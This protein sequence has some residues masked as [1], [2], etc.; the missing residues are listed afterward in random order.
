MPLFLAAVLCGCAPVLGALPP[1]NSDTLIGQ[2]ER[3]NN[4]GANRTRDPADY[5]LDRIREAQDRRPPTA[6]TELDRI[7][8]DLEHERVLSEQARQEAARRQ[9]ARPD[10]APR[11]GPV[12]LHTYDAPSPLEVRHALAGQIQSL[13]AERDRQFRQL[14]SDPRAQLQAR[15]RIQSDF[16]QNI[17]RL[18]DRYDLRLLPPTTQ[19]QRP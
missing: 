13:V 17:A 5:E 1:D 19:P 6:G 11:G 9:D 12:G 8:R 2:T 7:D 16:E 3:A 10:A 15:Q 14:P 4:R 18:L